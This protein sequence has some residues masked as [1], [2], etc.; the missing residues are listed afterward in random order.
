M[1]IPITFSPTEEIIFAHFKELSTKQQTQFQQLGTIYQE[2]NAKLNLI[3]RK[4]ISNLYLR[5]VLHALSIPKLVQFQ[6]NTKLLDVGTGGGFPGIPLAIFFPEAH[7]HLIDS[8]AKKVHAVEEISRALGLKNV[9]TQVVRAE[10]ITQKYDFIL[11]RAVTD[12]GVFYNWV[13][14]KIATTSINAIPNGILYFKG[15]ELVQLRQPY[16]I[17]CLNKFF[18]DPFFETKQLIYIP[19]N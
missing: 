10:N 8:I 15:N 14:D 19:K 13:K 18:D 11:G 5:H 12:L 7:F 16:H 3:S 1:S 6:P 2:W 4:D 9:T 17:Y